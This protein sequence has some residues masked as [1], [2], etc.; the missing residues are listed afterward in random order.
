MLKSYQG[1]IS[2]FRWLYHPRDDVTPV[3]QYGLRPINGGSL[4]WFD[5][6]TEVAAPA[7]AATDASGVHDFAGQSSVEDS[8]TAL[9][10]DQQSRA[11]TDASEVPAFDYVAR[12]LAT[13]HAQN[14][15][16]VERQWATVRRAVYGESA[17]PEVPAANNV[18]SV[19]G[20]PTCTHTNERT[21]LGPTTSQIN[22][23]C[24][25]CKQSWVTFPAPAATEVPAA[26]QESG[27]TFE[28][29]FLRH[30]GKQPT[31]AS[32]RYYALTKEAEIAKAAWVAALAAAQAAPVAAEAPKAVEWGYAKTVGNAIAQLQTMD[33][34]LPIYAA[35]HLEDGRCIARGVT[36]SRERVVGERWIDNRNKDVPYSIVVWSQP[37]ESLFSPTASTSTA[38]PAGE[39]G[40]SE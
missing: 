18:V 32:S 10:A 37:V 40:K 3:L 1:G 17:A 26:R 36:F 31:L 39:V 11:A 15:D 33:A 5:V 23:F 8:L 30:T 27:E 25:D 22:H 16:A 14:S 9:V 6:P 13:A 21:S 29:W 4:D 24:P 12:D 2:A 38:A 20:I 19:N 35:F 28:Q 7:S 34:E